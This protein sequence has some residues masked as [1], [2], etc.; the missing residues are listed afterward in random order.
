ME[1]MRGRQL[2]PH[3]GESTTGFN[4]RFSQT[5]FFSSWDF[6]VVMMRRVSW[7]DGVG[8]SNVI[9]EQY[10]EPVGE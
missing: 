2:K 7:S 6:F 9:D 1:E 5:M 8:G 4:V 3:V 10:N